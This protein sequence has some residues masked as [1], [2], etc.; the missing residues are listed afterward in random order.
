MWTPH[1]SGVTHIL[2]CLPFLVS[3]LGFVVHKLTELN[4]FNTLISQDKNILNA[5]FQWIQFIYCGIP[6]LSARCLHSVFIEFDIFIE[7][8][9]VANKMSSKLCIKLTETY[10]LKVP[11]MENFQQT[12]KRTVQINLLPPD[13]TYMASPTPSTYS[14]TSSFYIN[15]FSYII[16]KQVLGILSFINLFLYVSL[17]DKN[18]PPPRPFKHN[19]NTTFMLKE[20]ALLFKSFGLP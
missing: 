3:S 9:N 1:S 5:V 2:S 15:F 18:Y 4:N 11:I 16:L 13:P 19:H 7:F 20:L 6:A 17:K 12:P 8:D 14:S 10:F